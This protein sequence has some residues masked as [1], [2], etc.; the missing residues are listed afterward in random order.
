MMIQIMTVQPA[1]ILPVPVIIEVNISRGIKFHLSGNVHTSIK[2]NRQRIYA[3]LKNEGW[4]WPGQRITLNFRPLD[5]LK[6]GTHYD[7]PMAV[8]IL[9]ASGQINTTWIANT[10]FFGAVQLDGTIEPSLDSFGI[11]EVLQRQGI[12]RAVLHVASTDLQRLSASFPSI[13]IINVSTMKEAIDYLQVGEKF[14]TVSTAPPSSKLLVIEDHGCFSEVKGLQTF[15]RAL[16]V[17]AAGGHH[18]LL[19]GAPGIGKTMLLERFPSILPEVNP[20]DAQ[21]V[22]MMASKNGADFGGHRPFVRSV[23]TDSMKMLFGCKEV[24]QIKDYFEISDAFSAWK[25][26]PKLST[27]A[28][29]GK[30]HRALGGVLFIDELATFPRSIHDALLNHLERYRV[31]LVMAMNPCHCGYFNHP[32]ISCTCPAAHLHRYQSTLSGALTDRIDFQLSNPPHSKIIR[33]ERSEEIKER[34]EKAYQR[35]MN[36]SGQ[37]NARLTLEQLKPLVLYND[38]MKRIFLNRLKTHKW[39][40]RKQRSVLSMTLSIADLCD[41]NPLPQH[42]EEAARSSSFEINET[43]KEEHTSRTKF[44]RPKLIIDRTI[45]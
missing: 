7:L 38:S 10:A 23:T 26:L 14:T 32:S 19:N 42:L 41:T 39:S 21:I 36:R 9:A 18:V 11:L 5:L 13:D 37:Q 24:Q 28:A 25:T 8:G 45:D 2:E 6:K 16:E 44:Q 43:S 31:Q 4:H 34:V 35:Q 33:P 20:E 40:L 12:K 30:F 22:A 1:A 27:K 15:K 29:L 17:A 3:T